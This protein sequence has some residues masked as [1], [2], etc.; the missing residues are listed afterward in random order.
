[1]TDKPLKVKVTYPSNLDSADLKTIVK[2]VN[3]KDYAVKE[4][5][6][7]NGLVP[8]TELFCYEL[9]KAIDIPTPN[10]QIIEMPDNSLAFG[11]EWEGGV[12]K[13]DQNVIM[14][15]LLGRLPIPDFKVFVSELYAL[16]IFVNNVDRHFGNYIFRE[17]YS[18][19]LSLAFDFSRALYAVNKNNPF[20]NQCIID[21]KCNT[22]SCNN[23][24]KQF[25]QFDSN[26]TKATLDKI[27]NISIDTIQNIIDKIPD[28]W[29]DNS[30]RDNLISFWK[31]GIIDRINY[32]K[33]KV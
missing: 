4:I 17:S 3:K 13:I 7:G 9:S 27:Y 31:S 14:N 10:Y 30:Q 26:I 15:I 8:A 2:A 12:V 32:L 24:L 22:Y 5:T 16:D 29:L 18:G 6:D 23:I 28:S 1:M 19:I 25:N 11:S 33:G 21:T 20:E